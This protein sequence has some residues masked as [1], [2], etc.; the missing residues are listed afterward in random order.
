MK[1]RKLTA[2]IVVLALALM[3]TVS[4]AAEARQ[5]GDAR[6]STE[7]YV[8]EGT[9][10]NFSEEYVRSEETSSTFLQL[11][12]AGGSYNDITYRVRLCNNQTLAPT[13]AAT[14]WVH[15]TFSPQYPPYIAYRYN[16]GYFKLESH[17]SFIE[18]YATGYWRP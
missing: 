8:N 15:A 3:G 2:L 13:G 16:F 6:F 9:K 7:F 17:G 18:A 10:S 11:T 12:A 14:D 1:K 5:V 4:L